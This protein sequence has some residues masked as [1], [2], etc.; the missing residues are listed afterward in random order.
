MV[1][2]FLSYEN[3]ISPKKSPQ[4]YRFSLT[5]LNERILENGCKTPV[6]AL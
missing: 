6:H 4:K 1:Y 3:K 2:D 5:I